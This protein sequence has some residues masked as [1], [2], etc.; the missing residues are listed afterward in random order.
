MLRPVRPRRETVIKM[1]DKPTK[2]KWNLAGCVC[3]TSIVSVII[4]IAAVI[5]A[6]ITVIN[7]GNL[8]GVESRETSGEIRPTP[9][10]TSLDSTAAPIAMTMPNDVSAFAGAT[11]AIYSTTSQPHTVTISAGALGTTWDGVNLVATFGGAPGDG[12]EYRVLAKDLIVVT[13]VKNVVFS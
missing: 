9:F 3:A 1:D 11:R 7:Q 10:A 5:M 12:F 13:S 2:R 6:T 8:T 4:A